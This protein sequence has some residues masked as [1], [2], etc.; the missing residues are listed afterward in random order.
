[1]YKNYLRIHSAYSG[2]LKKLGIHHYYAPMG[3]YIVIGKMELMMSDDNNIYELL[4]LILE[5]EIPFVLGSYDQCRN[6][7][8]LYY[9]F[10]LLLND[11]TN[12][13]FYDE[14]YYTENQLKNIEIVNIMGI[15]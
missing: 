10:G 2:I 14:R 13:I 8:S 11:Q 9:S 6:E 1:M 3:K 4:K 12:E 5:Y 7:P 15:I